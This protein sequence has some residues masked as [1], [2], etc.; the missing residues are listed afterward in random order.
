MELELV[1]VAAVSEEFELYHLEQKK[2]NSL[3]NSLLDWDSLPTS[4]RQQKRKKRG[5]PA[6][7]EPAMAQL[8]HPQQ[9]H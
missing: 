7:L 6:L 8:Q 1:V 4:Q 2:E 5:I 3:T 9:C